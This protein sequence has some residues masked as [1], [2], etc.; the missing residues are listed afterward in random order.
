MKR[1]HWIPLTTAILLATTATAGLAL[2]P[3]DWD[4]GLIP[5]SQTDVENSSLVQYDLLNSALKARRPPEKSTILPP[6]R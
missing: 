1:K 3:R 6:R 5:T 2:E 4:S